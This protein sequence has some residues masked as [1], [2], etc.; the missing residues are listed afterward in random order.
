MIHIVLK[1]SASNEVLIVAI[2][3]RIF[4]NIKCINN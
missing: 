2:A 1:I 3:I 4:N